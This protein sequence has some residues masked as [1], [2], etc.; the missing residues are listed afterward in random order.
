[1]Y[2]TAELILKSYLPTKLEIGM[3][4]YR[5]ITVGVPEP[6]HEVWQLME[7]PEDEHNFQMVNG[8]PVE[9]YI[10]GGEIDI[11]AMPSEIGWF[12]V[13]EDVD[14]LYDITLVEINKII[15][16]YKGLLEIEVDEDSEE[17][18]APLYIENKVIIKYLE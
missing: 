12:D 2:I 11:L 4:F 14:E 8:A 13:G 3:Y 10:I 9:M 18:I 15:Q 1:M 6:V 17:E 7:L 16:E 5:I